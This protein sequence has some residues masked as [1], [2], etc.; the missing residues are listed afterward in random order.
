MYSDEINPTRNLR[1][2]KGLKAKKKKI[3]KIQ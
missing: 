1:I 3:E 2:P